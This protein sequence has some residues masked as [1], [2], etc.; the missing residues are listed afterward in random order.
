VIIILFVHF[1]YF[2]LIDWI[3]IQVDANN[4]FQHYVFC[5]DFF[6]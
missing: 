3:G 2:S 4:F 5:K 1:P 6:L